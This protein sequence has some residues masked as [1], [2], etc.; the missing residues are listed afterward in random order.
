M[1]GNLNFYNY[2]SLNNSHEHVP[3]TIT[4]VFDILYTG[5]KG[6][7]FKFCIGRVLKWA[8]TWSD[9]NILLIISKY[10]AS[11]SLTRV[12]FGPTQWDFSWPKG[13]KMKNLGFLRWNFPNLEVAELTQTEQQKSYSKFTLIPFKFFS[14]LFGSILLNLSILICLFSKEGNNCLE[15]LKSLISM[16]K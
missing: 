3:T 8:L 15:R 4:N 12:L 2:N 6:K 10:E 11:S 9:S 16:E 14:N 1:A 13:K 5:Q 7:I